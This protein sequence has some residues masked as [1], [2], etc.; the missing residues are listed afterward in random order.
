MAPKS[1]ADKRLSC[2][3]HILRM[4]PFS[5][6]QRAKVKLPKRSEKR[7]YDDQ[8]SLKGLKFVAAKY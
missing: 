3:S 6:V 8:S 7:K 1:A 5:R 2:I 4:I